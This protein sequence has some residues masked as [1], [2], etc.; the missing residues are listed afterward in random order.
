M[1]KVF[2]QEGLADSTH[3]AGNF[4]NI[5]GTPLA[6]VTSQ[7]GG[8][9]KV[10]Q[11]TNT[12]GIGI[13]TINS[14]TFSD[15]IP[16]PLGSGANNT[17]VLRTSFDFV[18]PASLEGMK[19]AGSNAKTNKVIIYL[20]GLAEDRNSNVDFQLRGIF[21]ADEAAEQGGVELVPKATNKFSVD[22]NAKRYSSSKAFDLTSSD[23][24]LS[25]GTDTFY[26]Y[27]ADDASNTNIVPACGTFVKVYIH[28]E[29]VTPKNPE[30]LT[31]AHWS[32]VAAAPVE[33]ESVVSETSVKLTWGEPAGPLKY[34]VVVKET[35]P[36]NFSGDDGPLLK[37]SFTSDSAVTIFNKSG[38]DSYKLG[39]S[40]YFTGTYLDNTNSPVFKTGAFAQNQVESLCNVTSDTTTF[41][42]SGGANGPFND[43][44]LGT[45]CTTKTLSN[46]DLSGVTDFEF[47]YTADGGYYHQCGA[48]AQGVIE[49][50]RE[51]VSALK[52]SVSDFASATG[53]SVQCGC[54]IPAE[55]GVSYSSDKLEV[56]ITITG[57]VEP[58]YVVFQLYKKDEINSLLINTTV[59]DTSMAEI[60]AYATT[61]SKA[62]DNVKVKF[63]KT[64]DTLSDS[65]AATV[66]DLGLAGQ[67]AGEFTQATA[68]LMAGGV[69]N[70]VGFK[71]VDGDDKIK[72]S[73][74]ATAE[75][76]L[77][78]EYC[79]SA[80]DSTVQVKCFLY[81]SAPTKDK[82][83]EKFAANFVQDSAST[84]SF[85]CTKTAVAAD[86]PQGDGA[87]AKIGFSVFLLALTALV[88]EF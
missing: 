3:A 59:A 48:S 79:L 30:N 17:N 83:S 75:M 5:D 18:V 84:Q 62:K 47:F 57:A 19:I 8:S 69:S 44:F 87:T 37:F 43:F 21:G 80:E 13:A 11:V 14:L 1:L 55:T 45:L 24:K 22:T 56:K 36:S 50:Q 46:T 25:S 4:G 41:S 68:N 20:G 23:V 74:A 10:T 58:P 64:D 61:W 26:F 16:G 28:H 15:G 65:K 31:A 6:C 49:S 39:Y 38:T 85:E 53:D 71:T 32:D 67:A 70:V 72:I 66:P 42:G 82:V 54:S 27:L 34:N 81:H 2:L 52:T 7:S 29:D 73:A 77:K 9:S 40:F 33:C 12:S 78:S 86:D 76:D 63:T 51:D 60:I 35:F 88:M